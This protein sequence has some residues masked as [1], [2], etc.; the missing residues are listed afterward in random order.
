MTNNFVKLFNVCFELL[1]KE[2]VFCGIKVTLLGFIL[3]D[4]VAVILL[5]TVFSLFNIR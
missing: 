1:S 4:V 2:F 5:K 3:F